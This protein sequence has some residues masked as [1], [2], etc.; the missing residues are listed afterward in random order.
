ML[1]PEEIKE[2]EFQR[3][4]PANSDANSFYVNWNDRFR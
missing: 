4:E 1:L 3:T 2:Y